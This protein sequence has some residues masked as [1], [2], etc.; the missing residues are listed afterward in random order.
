MTN[1]IFAFQQPPKD[2][3]VGNL[4]L[5]D[6]WLWITVKIP[7]IW[8]ILYLRQITI[9][10]HLGYSGFFQP[11]TTGSV[12]NL[13]AQ[14]KQNYSGGFDLRC[15]LVSSWIKRQ[16]QTLRR[17]LMTWEIQGYYWLGCFFFYPLPILIHHPNTSWSHEI[18]ELKKP[19][20]TWQ[21]TFAV[22]QYSEPYKA[23]MVLSKAKT[24]ESTSSRK[25]SD[26]ETLAER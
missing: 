8:T 13:Q 17:P 18:H 25:M 4:C 5:E 3:L 24:S 6:P 26:D 14:Q 10:I 21:S 11:R 1:R 9:I 22:M 2:F 7:S 23:K 16:S 19:T 12:I 15:P 20:E